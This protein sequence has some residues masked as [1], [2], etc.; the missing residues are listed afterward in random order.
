[1]KGPPHGSILDV[2]EDSITTLETVKTEYFRVLEQNFVERVRNSRTAFD[3]FYFESSGVETFWDR[4]MAIFLFSARP[5]SFAIQNLRIQILIMSFGLVRLLETILVLISMFDASAMQGDRMRLSYMESKDSKSHVFFDSIRVLNGGCTMD[6]VQKITTTNASLEAFFSRNISWDGLWLSVAHHGEAT[7]VLIEWTSGAMPWCQLD[8]RPWFISRLFGVIPSSLDADFT[9]DLGA[10]WHWILISCVGPAAFFVGCIVSVTFGSFGRG[11]LATLSLACTYLLLAVTELISASYVSFIIYAASDSKLKYFWAS[12]GFLMAAN[13]AYS[14]CFGLLSLVLVWDSYTV[15]FFF[16]VHVVVSA[17]CIGEMLQYAFESNIRFVPKLI[18]CCF[19][20]LLSASVYVARPLARSR[21]LLEPLVAEDT[22]R[23]ETAWA[24]YRVRHDV[25]RALDGL[26]RLTE[27]IMARLDRTGA[28]QYYPRIAGDVSGGLAGEDER[29]PVASLGQ[30]FDQAAVLRVI[31]Q[32]KLCA[33]LRAACPRATPAGD[34]LDGAQRAE[35]L[36]LSRARVLLKP[37][38]RAFEKMLTCYGAD[39]SRVLDICRASIEFE[40]VA[41]LR[42]VLN[43][44]RRDPETAIVRVKNGYHAGTDSRRSG[45]FRSLFR[46]TRV[47][48][49]PPSICPSLASL[50]CYAKPPC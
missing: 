44:V 26:S 12:D 39:A 36:A 15:D 20:A 30:L 29:V 18:W 9:I 1:M 17:I 42:A 16:I 19:P 10:P 23:Y 48:G 45:G 25:A 47:K 37:R 46:E 49:R 28:R 35:P 21:I 5:F 7:G 31:L 40:G 34:G 2:S 50:A 43:A 13:V 6:T 38:Q 24:N 27:H 32:S 11:R 8:S 22:Q 4:S 3:E 14:L 33:L 41:E